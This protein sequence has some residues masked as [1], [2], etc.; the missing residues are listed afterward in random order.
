MQL[1]GAKAGEKRAVNV[2]FPVE[3]VT[4]QLA[5]KKGS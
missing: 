5:G 4:P 1:I 2:D 3:F